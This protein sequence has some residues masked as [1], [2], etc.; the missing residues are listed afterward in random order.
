MEKIYKKARAKLNLTLNIVDKRPDGYHNIESVFQKIGLY[1]ELYVEKTN[2]GSIE[3]ICNVKELEGS[4]N[5]IWRAYNAL[6]LLTPDKISG[7]KVTLIKHIPAESGLGGGSTDCAAFLHS[8]NALFDLGYSRE[9]LVN[10][11]KTIGADV[12]ACLHP[13]CMLGEGIGEIITPINSSMKY[14]LVLAKPAASFSTKMMYDV[15]DNHPGFTQRFTSKDMIKAL[16]SS[17]LKLLCKSFYNAFEEV[18]KENKEIQRIRNVLSENNALGT[19]MTGSGSCV[20]GVF[21]NKEES[22]KA[23]NILKES[24][25]VYWSIAWNRN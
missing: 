8:M 16:E 9:D 1:D 21:A 19:M 7:I 24:H 13:N 5:I 3:I 25:E 14:Y 6:K 15:I 10:I 2:S 12:P 20:F 11:G 17:N 4:N 22:K 18:V 23:Y